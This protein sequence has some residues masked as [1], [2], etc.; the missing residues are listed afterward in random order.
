MSSCVILACYKTSPAF[1]NERVRFKGGNFE[2]L[3]RT[4]ARSRFS[5]CYNCLPNGCSACFVAR[6]NYSYAND[7]TSVRWINHDVIILGKESGI[8]TIIKVIGI[9]AAIRATVVCTIKGCE[10]GFDSRPT[11]ACI[12]V[13]RTGWTTRFRPHVQWRSDR[14]TRP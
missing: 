13:H 7:M 10:I 11:R 5:R 12:T 8:S 4:V 1:P 3:L 2:T 6:E 14:R 9:V